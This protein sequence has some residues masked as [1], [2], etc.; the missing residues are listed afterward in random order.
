MVGAS[1]G[2]VGTGGTDLSP[3]KRNWR[4]WNIIIS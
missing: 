4:E 3:I 1:M 2:N